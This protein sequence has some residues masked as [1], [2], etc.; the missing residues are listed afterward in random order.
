MKFETTEKSKSMTEGGN[1]VYELYTMKGTDEENIQFDMEFDRTILK[2]GVTCNPHQRSGA[3]HM[4]KGYHIRMNVLNSD[5]SRGQ[6]FY[7]ESYY[8]MEYAK[9]YANLF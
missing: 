1:Y 4:N 3:G 6:A 8:A 7:L 5:I 2:Y 9:K